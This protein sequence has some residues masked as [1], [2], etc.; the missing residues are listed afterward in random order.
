MNSKY[1]IVY[2]RDIPAQVKARSETAR[3]ARELSPRFQQAIDQAAMIA[4]A[5][6][7]DEYLAGWRTS[8]WRGGEQDAERLADEIAA[9]LEREYDDDRL[10]EVAGAGGYQAAE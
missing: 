4:G 9:T 2:W 10:A 5:A 1:Q 6:E 7:T 3:A 8:E